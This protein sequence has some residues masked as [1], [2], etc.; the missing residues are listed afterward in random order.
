MRKQ[1][2]SEENAQMNATIDHT[3]GQIDRN[4]DFIQLESFLNA[5]T[6]RQIL[7][8]LYYMRTEI[9][10]DLDGKRC[11]AYTKMLESKDPLTE[12]DIG[13]KDLVKILLDRKLA[14]VL[15]RDRRTILPLHKEEATFDLGE[16]PGQLY[17]SFKYLFYFLANN[18]NGWNEGLLK[19]ELQKL[20]GVRCRKD[21]NIKH[22]YVKVL[23]QE[24][25]D[26]SAQIIFEGDV[27]TSIRFVSTG[28]PS[29]FNSSLFLAE[30]NAHKVSKDVAE[31]KLD[32]EKLIS[33][34]LPI[35]ENHKDMI[36]TVLRKAR[37]A[38]V[39]LYLPYLVN[40][41]KE[42]PDYLKEME[43]AAGT[44]VDSKLDTWQ[45]TLQ[46][47]L[48]SLTDL[49]NIQADN[50]SDF[51][52]YFSDVTNYCDIPKDGDKSKSVAE[53]FGSHLK[54]ANKVIVAST[55]LDT[56]DAQIIYHEMI[57]TLLNEKKKAREK[58]DAEKKAD[59]MKAEGKNEAVDS[60]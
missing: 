29:L 41:L 21:A 36:K 58:R 26:E 1:Y 25:V 54:E 38:K 52:S 13:D 50:D 16:E 15:D 34:I 30:I 14:K 56:L 55:G 39:K 2:P 23:G 12:A 32:L 22:Y 5:S 51:K 49:E 28:L 31:T 27:Y 45:K 11:K 7:L 8:S 18:F 24:N 37:K 17:V 57:L 19:R 60:E 53:A 42:W 3:T 59:D 9:L 35:Y 4:V 48:V 40:N 10:K 43:S 47:M 33:A 6:T 44:T 20:H 46:R